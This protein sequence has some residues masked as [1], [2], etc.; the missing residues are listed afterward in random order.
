MRQAQIN[1]ERVDR[2]PGGVPAIWTVDAHPTDSRTTLVTVY[3]EDGLPTQLEFWM[4]AMA[5]RAALPGVDFDHFTVTSRACR[6]VPLPTA[7]NG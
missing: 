2:L 5:C 6:V 3:L 7:V 4:K 1:V